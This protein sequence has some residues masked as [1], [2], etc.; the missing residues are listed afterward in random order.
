MFQKASLPNKGASNGGSHVTV[1][2]AKVDTSDMKTDSGD[3]SAHPKATSHLIK[4]GL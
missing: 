4:D 1:P 2:A 3:A